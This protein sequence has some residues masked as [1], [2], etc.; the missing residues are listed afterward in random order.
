MGPVVSKKQIERVKAYIDLGVEEG[1]TL[2]SGGNLRANMGTGWFIEPTCFVDV[3]NDMRIAQEEIFGPVLVVIPFDNDDDAVRIANDSVYSLSGGVW[4]GGQRRPAVWLI[5]AVWYRPRL[6]R[7]G[8]RGISRDQGYG[9]PSLSYLCA[10]VVSIG[11]HHTHRHLTRT[12]MSCS[13]PKAAFQDLGL[14]AN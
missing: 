5:Q 6:G 2:L 4:S 10:A 7:R 14:E 13:W 9:I 3:S 1:A 11:V 8:N 12:R